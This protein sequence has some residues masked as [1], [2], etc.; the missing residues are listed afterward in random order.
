MTDP[1]FP[2]TPKGM[3]IADIEVTLWDD[4]NDAQII[5]IKADDNGGGSFPVIDL[6]NCPDSKLSLDPDQLVALAEWARALCHWVDF[7]REKK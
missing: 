2:P 1:L 6:R 7:Q 5:T 4:E 3:R